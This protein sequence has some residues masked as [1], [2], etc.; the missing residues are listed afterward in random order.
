[1]DIKNMI[2]KQAS[3]FKN[4]WGVSI[5][6]CAVIGILGVSNYCVNF[7]NLGFCL[8]FICWLETVGKLRDVHQRIE[9]DSGFQVGMLGRSFSQ[10]V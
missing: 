3:G 1:M 9:E 2:I 10:F 4:F 5:S 8:E 7:E 6:D